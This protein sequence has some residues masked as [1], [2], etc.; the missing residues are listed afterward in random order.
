MPDSFYNLNVLNGF[1]P[2]TRKS[3]AP[4]IAASHE[5]TEFSS[6][7]LYGQTERFHPQPQMSELS[8]RV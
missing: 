2:K 5:N 3:D 7:Y 4:S 8:R 1:C 6:M